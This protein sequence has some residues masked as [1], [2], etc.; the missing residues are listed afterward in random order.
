M[1]TTDYSKQLEE[2]TEVEEAMQLAAVT[3]G[4]EAIPRAVATAAAAVEVAEKEV[5][6]QPLIVIT[7]GINPIQP[8]RTGAVPAEPCL[9]IQSST[10]IEWLCAV[11]QLD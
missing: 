10:L 11:Q 2:A 9:K 4:E 3:A 1:R 8:R 7:I 6:M 5:D